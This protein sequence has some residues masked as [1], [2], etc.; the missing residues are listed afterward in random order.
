MNQKR[1]RQLREQAMEESPVAAG[2]EQ[3]HLCTKAVYGVIPGGIVAHM[4]CFQIVCTGWRARY[5]DLKKEYK[6]KPW[7]TR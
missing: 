2:Y 4:E 5:K 6:R 3:R 7:R 1:A